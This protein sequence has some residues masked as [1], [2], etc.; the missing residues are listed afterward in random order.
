MSDIFRNIQWVECLLYMDDITDP[1][2]T[3]EET[4]LRLEHVFQRLQSAKIKL[5]PS[6]CIFFQ[7]SVKLLGHEVS[8]QGIHTDKDTIKAVQEWRKGTVK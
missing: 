7:K 3:V 6:K 4:L 5:K 1:A 2:K 8:E